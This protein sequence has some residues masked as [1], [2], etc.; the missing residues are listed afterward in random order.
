LNGCVQAFATCPR[1][2]GVVAHARQNLTRLRGK[3]ADE[4]TRRARV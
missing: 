4:L 1:E 2:G 3:A